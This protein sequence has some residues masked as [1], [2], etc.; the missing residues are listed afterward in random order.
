MMCGRARFVLVDSLESVEVGRRATGCVV[1]PRELEIFEDHFPGHPIVPG[2]LLTEAMGQTAGWLLACTLRFERWPLLAT[3]DQA[4]FY[5]RVLPGESIVLD[6]VI[7]SSRADAFELQTEARV[8]GRRVARARLLFRAERFA[9]AEPEARA[10]EQW[11]RDTFA[12]LTGG[13]SAVPS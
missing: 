3:I 9:D 8:N 13:R 12:R 2:T 5:R 7:Q 10:L 4:K 11:A 6:A 1:F